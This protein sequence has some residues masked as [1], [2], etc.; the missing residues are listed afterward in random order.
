MNLNKL[1]IDQSE[2]IILGEDNINK[3]LLQ[4]CKDKGKVILPYQG[5][6]N[7]V[8]AYSDFYDSLLPD[9]EEE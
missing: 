5:Q 4:Y 2:G 6:E 8:D 1:A 9:I 7:Y 3:D